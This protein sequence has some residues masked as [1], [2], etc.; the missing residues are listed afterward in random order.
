MFDYNYNLGIFQ[1]LTEFFEMAEKK[2][3]SSVNAHFSRTTNV[4]KQINDKVFK[5]FQTN[6]QNVSVKKEQ[7]ILFSLLC[8]LK[9]NFV[10][11]FMIGKKFSAASARFIEGLL[12]TMKSIFL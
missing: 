4:L 2:L 7:V 8:V 1:T 6:F 10:I 9:S 11:T 5:L 3:V 12:C